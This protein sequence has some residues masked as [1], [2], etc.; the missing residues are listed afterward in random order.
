MTKRLPVLTFHALAGTASPV[1]FAPETF[2]A[3]VRRLARAGWRTVPAA[4]AV[5]FA[6]GETAL[7]DRSLVITFDDG[8]ASVLEHAAP[9]L[10]DAG[11]GA[12][13]FLATDL[14]DR[15]TIFPGERSCPGEPALT[16]AQARELASA[17]FEIGSHARTHRDLRTLGDRDLEDELV[18]SRR[19]LEDRLSV[20]VP[21]HA[22]PF[23]GHDGR[24][25]AA[26]AR[27]YDGAFTT[28]LDYVESGDPAWTLPR[29]DAHYLRFLGRRGDPAGLP[30]RAW[31]ALRG[32]GRALRARLG[33]G[34]GS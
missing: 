28:R 22:Y 19:L 20:P 1:A 11:F 8:Y 3:M 10:R 31:V 33:G 34:D 9:A 14:L 13:L 7:P 15:P 23:G 26:C 4:R 25:A 6:R 16:W 30:M 27:A 18:G 2:R 21:L 5:A 12:V 29:L 32:A 24:V 17:G